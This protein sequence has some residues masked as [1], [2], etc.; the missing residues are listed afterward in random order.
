MRFWDVRKD[1]KTE[2]IR[3]TLSPGFGHA[4]LAPLVSN[5]FD[6][7]E[8]SASLCHTGGEWFPLHVQPSV[9]AFESAHLKD[10]ERVVR[11]ERCVTEVLRTGKAR[12]AEHGGFCDVFAPIF[13]QDRVTA[14]LVSG[15]F[16]LARPTG[17]DVLTHWRWLTGRQGH[18]TDPQFAAYLAATLGTLVLDRGM[19]RSFERLVVCLTELMSGT[20]AAGGL[21]SEADRLR[22]ELE[23]ARFVE[24]AW[25]T[26]AEMIDE[27]SSEAWRRDGSRAD[28]RRVGL[29]RPPEAVLV[30]FTVNLIA[31]DPVDEAIRLDAFKRH[32][33]ALALGFGNAIAGQVG[34]HGVVF[35]S[36]E[37]GSKARRRQKLIELGERALRIARKDFGFALH[38]GFA[39]AP[40]VI[41]LEQSFHG[42]LSA[43]EL[44]LVQGV[45]LRTAESGAGPAHSA[46]HL[47]EELGRDVEEHPERLRARFDRYLETV[48]SR[49]GYRIDPI[50]VHLEIGFEKLAEPLLRNG[51][52]DQKSLVTMRDS[53]E[54]AAAEVRTIGELFVAYRKAIEDLTH[55]LQAPVAARHDRNLRRGIDYM[56]AHYIE[57]ITR[58]KVARVAGLTPS[59]FSVL[60]KRHE[61]K[62]FESSLRDLRVRRA[63]Q[64]LGGGE[65][66]VT[67]VAELSGFHSLQYFS[68]VFR[69]ALG[70]TARSYRQQALTAARRTEQKYKKKYT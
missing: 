46:R 41:P 35:L 44:A 60:F 67:R 58:A 23:K 42:A 51:A 56:R 13:A 26:V 55:A 49:S 17:A 34:D 24:R 45:K 50:R 48:A 5:I 27:R 43:A 20:G 31:G 21:A 7:L 64:L 12:R 8:V 15:P 38:F 59:Y 39:D 22:V 30:G 4:L 36:A 1:P 65:L 11:N 19:D 14:I 53:L 47:R 32:S 66:N 16:L 69:Q 9:L 63:Q 29:E 2:A 25:K 68:R 54:R 37:R 40:A 57:P 3:H 70:T 61:G 33:V 52:V 18:P 10:H 62:T 28:L 6:T